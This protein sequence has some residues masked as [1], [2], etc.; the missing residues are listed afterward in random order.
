MSFGAMLRPLCSK[1]TG[2]SQEH[3][4][5][6]DGEPILEEENQSFITFLGEDPFTVQSERV[7]GP[8]IG[9]DGK[10]EREALTTL[11]VEFATDVPPDYQEGQ[12]LRVIGP[13][14]P[15]EVQPPPDAKPGSRQRYRLAPKPE[16]RVTVPPGVQPGMNMTFKKNNGVQIT[17]QVPP[18]V[19]PGEAFTVNPPALMVRVPDDAQAGD[20]VCFRNT[21]RRT[22]DDMEV[23]EWCRARIPNSLQPGK[24][25]AAR[26]PCPSHP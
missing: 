15:V 18:N 2:K 12:P 17:I 14:G 9:P 7:Q 26:L 16:F 11:A 4:L 6:E 22:G 25:F 19:G 13:H 3:S 8:A 20:V 21:V 10:F 24:Y 5:L 23:T 1:L